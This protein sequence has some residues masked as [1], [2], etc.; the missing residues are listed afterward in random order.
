MPLSTK[1]TKGHDPLPPLPL[2]DFSDLRLPTAWMSQKLRQTSIHVTAVSFCALGD[3]RM[4]GFFHWA[5]GEISLNSLISTVLETA[6]RP[7]ITGAIVMPMPV[8]SFAENAW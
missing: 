8:V 7:D 4:V 3:L 6:S 1:S 5:R 2:L